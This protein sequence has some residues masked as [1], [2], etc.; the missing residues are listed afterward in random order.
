M[1]FN[2]VNPPDPLDFPKL[3]MCKAIFDSKFFFQP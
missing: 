1:E 3:N 2:R